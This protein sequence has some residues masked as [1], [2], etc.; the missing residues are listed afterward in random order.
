LLAL[1]PWQPALTVGP[2]RT[3]HTVGVPLD[4]LVELD[5]L[6]PQGLVTGTQTLAGLPSTVETAVHEDPL[7]QLCPAEQSTA[8]YESPAN[9]PQIVPPAQSALVTQSAQLPGGPLLVPPV[10]PVPLDAF[11]CAQ[12]AGA[13]MVAVRQKRQPAAPG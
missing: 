7:A 2:S 8:Q 1:H 3:P 9:C 6:P 10:P 4:E 13:R 11:P 5:P 12:D